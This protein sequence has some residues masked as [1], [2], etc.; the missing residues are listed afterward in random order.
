MFLISKFSRLIAIV[1]VFIMFLGMG[2]TA[3]AKKPNNKKIHPQKNVINLE[4]K[5][6]VDDLDEA[7]WA[8]GSM[9]LMMSK[10]IFK[11]RGNGKMAPNASVSRAELLTAAVRMRLI[12]ENEDIDNLEEA[13]AFVTDA[14]AGDNNFNFSFEDNTLL[15]RGGAK[16]SAPYIY[17][18]VELG[19]INPE[20][21]KLQPMK[22]SS[23]AW[24][25]EVLVNTLEQYLEDE[26]GN[27]VFSDTDDLPDADV[28]YIERAVAAGLFNGYPDGSF[29]PNKPL[30]RA[31]LMT[32]MA[33]A[34]ADLQLPGQEGNYR[35]IIDE[36]DEDEITVALKG[37]GEE[38]FA[39]NDDTGVFVNS[40]E[41]SP[42]MLQE[43]DKVQL[44]AD[45]ELNADIIWASFEK[46]EISGLVTDVDDVDATVTVDVYEIEDAEDSD[47][48]VGDTE[49]FDVADYV[50]IKLQGEEEDIDA[51][52]EVEDNYAE[53]KLHGSLVIEIVIEEEEEQD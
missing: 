36:I 18:A 34:D 28:S 7:P 9:S 35:G 32:L 47:I 17:M 13:E 29:K 4:E 11:G 43:G 44:L 30:T 48:D 40:K 53:L 21:G 49:T 45:E 15:T 10:G 33:R 8:V 37:G 19:I 26:E 52:N 2:S 24:A 12:A 1:T 14:Y 39:L 22:P 20:E 6:K 3:W 46:W 41:G 31:E 38:T 5:F 23:R 27:L 51:L 16:W 25:A 42:E 50:N